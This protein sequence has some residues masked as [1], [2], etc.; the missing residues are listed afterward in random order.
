LPSEIDGLRR[1]DRASNLPHRPA[2]AIADEMAP[3]AGD[4][5]AM[6]LWRRHV[7]RAL[8]AARALKAGLPIPRLA[9]RDP[10]ALRALDRRHHRQG[11]RPPC[12]QG[13]ARDVTGRARRRAVAQR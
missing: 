12:V 4:Q 2:T 6:A 3:E 9:M 8:L 7:E 11:D 10:F 13:R 1:L 5:F